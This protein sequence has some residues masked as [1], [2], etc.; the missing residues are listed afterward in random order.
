MALVS[1]LL[2][3]KSLYCP[4]IP[5]KEAIVFDR[6]PENRVGFEELP[7]ESTVWYVPL[8]DV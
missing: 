8:F 3:I 5:V 7:P 1:G 6:T 4:L 2:A